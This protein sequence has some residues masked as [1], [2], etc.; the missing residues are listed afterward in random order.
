[1]TNDEVWKQ[2][3]MGETGM[4]HGLV[5]DA[6]VHAPAIRLHLPLSAS[7]MGSWG[8]KGAIYTPCQSWLQADCKPR[9]WPGQ[10]HQALEPCGPCPGT[11][12]C[13]GEINIK[14]DKNTMV[15][16]RGK[17]PKPLSHASA[18][19]L[20]CQRSPSVPESSALRPPCTQCRRHQPSG[21]GVVQPQSHHLP[22]MDLVCASSRRSR[23]ER[24]GGGGRARFEVQVQRVDV[25]SQSTSGRWD[26]SGLQFA[27]RT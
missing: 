16:K 10:G 24:G 4:R 6:Q 9:S 25:T 23:S 26:K 7:V 19:P 11:L 14:P 21:V 17:G 22:W 15:F 5:P 3:S 18:N 8:A 1:M 13:P 12:E 27:S 2:L 20:Q